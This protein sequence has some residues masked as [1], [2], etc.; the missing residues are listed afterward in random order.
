MRPVRILIRPRVVLSVFT[1]LASL[2]SAP[3][4]AL[5]AGTC[6]ATA[7]G[8]AFGT[9]DPTSPA[10]LAA[11]GTVSVT[12]Q[13]VTGSNSV[14]IQLSTGAS[15]SFANRTLL[16]GANALN[17]NLYVN[18]ANTTVWGDGT[19]STQAQTLGINAGLVQITVAANA[20]VYGLMPALQNPFPGAYADTITVTVNY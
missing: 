11:T 18:A 10:A 1:V 20:T 19:G 15:N 14:S 3:G 5:I 16:S 13:L 12:C 7:S 6:S 2:A 4:H 17:Y 9:Y 8:V